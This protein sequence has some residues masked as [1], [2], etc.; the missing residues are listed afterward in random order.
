MQKISSYLYPNRITVQCSQEPVLTEWRIVYQR[1]IKIYKGFTNIIEFDF[2][3]GQQR[4]VDVTGLTI[5]CTIMDVNGLEVFVGDVVPVEN[6]RGLARLKVDADALAQ[7]TQQ[8]LTYSL[9]II[10]NEGEKLPVYADTQF[11]VVG[12][13]ELIADATPR[14]V[15]SKIV[16]SFTSRRVNFSSSAESV[17]Y[18][19]SATF[20][21]VQNDV[22]DTRTISLDFVFDQLDGEVIVQMTDSPVISSDSEW[23]DI[24]SFE[25]TSNTKFLTKSYY[26]LKDFDDFTCWVRVKYTSTAGQIQK[27]VVMFNAVPYTLQISGDN[28]TPEFSDSSIQLDGAYASNSGTPNNIYLDGG[29]A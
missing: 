24:D 4:P 27:V 15:E 18:Y 26:E 23:K 19:S 11:G 6:K 25:V 29:G 16:K 14:L 17:Y 22:N 1:R 12:T 8:F 7:V 9:T 28:A 10:S 20:I 2:K 3:N 13:I 5:N 21:K